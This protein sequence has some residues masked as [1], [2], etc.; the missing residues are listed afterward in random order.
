MVTTKE[1]IFKRKLIIFQCRKSIPKIARRLKVKPSGIHMTIT[2][3]R[4]CEETQL[5]ICKILKISKE[6]FWPEFFPN[7]GDPVSHGAKITD[8][9]GAVN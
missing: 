5:A 2:G 7:G 1:H 3:K 6:E 9:A 8:Q 4:T